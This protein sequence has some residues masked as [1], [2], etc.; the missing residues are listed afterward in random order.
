MDTHSHHPDSSLSDICRTPGHES[1]LYPNHYDLITPDG[2]IVNLQRLSPTTAMAEVF[3]QKISP[4]FVGFQI[5]Q[6]LII[7]NIKSVLAQIGLDGYAIEMQLDQKARCAQVRV[8]LVAIG[9]IAQKFLDYLSVGAS[10][11]KLF[12]ADDRRRVRDPDYLSR[13]F[14]RS[15]RCGRP[16]LSLGGMQGSSDLILDKVDGR[17]VAYLSLQNGC[18]SYGDMIDGFLPTLAKGLCTDISMRD[19]L[20]IHQEWEPHAPRNV[21]KG[22]LLL[23]RTLPLHIRTVFARVVDGLL[24]SGYK[25]T[26]ASVLQPDTY[27]SGDIYELFGES[28]RGISD[29]PLEFYTLE[30][31][32]EYVF[33]QDRDQLQ[34]SLDDPQ[35]LFQAFQTAPEPKEQSAAVFVVKGE[36]ML[37]L[38]QSDW[39]IR[40]SVRHD[41][42]GLRHASRH[43]LMV[44]RYIMQQP[45]YPFLR[46]IEDDLITSQGVL[47]TR[48]FPTPFLKRMLLSSQVQQLLKGIYFQQP[49]KNFEDFFSQEDRALLNDLAKF[50]IPI[51]W[52]DDITQTILQYVQK[53]D[54]DSGIFVP[55]NEVNTFLDSTVFGVY[56]SNLLE[57]DFESEL[58][59]L[60]AGVLEMRGGVEHSL[61][62]KETPLSLV[63]G[64]G[65][66]AMEVG[67]RV[68]KRLGILSCGLVID[69]RSDD[70]TFVNEQL[71]N[72]HVEAK[73]TYRLDQLIERQAEFHLD[74]PIFLKGGIGTDFEF[75]LEQVRRKVGSTQPTPVLLFGE[76]D[77]WYNKV[78]VPFRQ[79]KELGTIVGS[80][81]LSNCFYV[82]QNAEQGLQVYRQFFSGELLIGPDGPTFE[83]GLVVVDDDW[84]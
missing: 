16:L 44:D 74:L 75:T 42:P 49:S 37:N 36:Q 45:P 23:V 79:N 24:A 35:A 26:A 2:T 5:D 47:L 67:N 18:V 61:L 84:R 56:G 65:P 6:E 15:D 4:A 13:M 10:I 52:V 1:Y 14:G 60:M 17:T 78:S 33:F 54:K 62:G 80:E 53:P 9:S 30:P 77:Y 82:V 76:P 58:T 51:Y 83:D 27:A 12:A 64:G 57:G 21:E 63:T 81:W 73:M 25:H 69:F 50:A 40:E 43:A 22:E 20:R 31:H 55:I 66:G 8:E 11:G 28:K 38:K 46:A 29:I 39:V 59:K 19:L 34:T 48:Y 68:A 71:Q 70:E 41:F 7:F 72:P 3:I 32:R